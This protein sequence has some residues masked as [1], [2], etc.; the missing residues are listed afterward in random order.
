MVV[1]TSKYFYFVYEFVYI[2]VFIHFLIDYSLDDELHGDDKMQAGKL[3][4]LKL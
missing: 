4:H 3:R 1:P 2:H